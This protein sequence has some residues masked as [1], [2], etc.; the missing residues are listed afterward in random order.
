MSSHAERIVERLREA[1]DNLR[2]DV[3]AQRVRWRYRMHRG[4]A[5]FDHERHEVHRR[6]RQG[7]VAWIRHGSLLSLLSAPVI[8]SLL[9]PFV[10]LDVWVTAYQWV[11]FPIYGIARVPRRRYFVLDRHRLAY[12]NGIE[13]VH[14][15]FCSYAN[16]FIAYVREVAARTEQYW[17][18]IKHASA[19]PAPHSRYHEFLDYGDAQG[20][21]DDL[22]E[23]RSR[24]RR[25]DAMAGQ[26]GQH[27]HGHGSL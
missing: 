18:P 17:C 21:R 16:G 14:C 27:R 1:E 10:V 2:R 22:A 6:L 4:R 26:T 12:L 8:Y 15:T 9:I 13:K 25:D 5:W 23:L 24:L 20:Y 19:I 3:D 7:V 11:C